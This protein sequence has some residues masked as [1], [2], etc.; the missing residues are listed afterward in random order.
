MICD[1]NDIHALNLIKPD[2]ECVSLNKLNIIEI[3]EFP[4][5]IKALRF[6]DCI[7]N[8]C[9]KLRLPSNL[10]NLRII[11]RIPRLDGLILPN[12]LRDLY[13]SST[14]LSDVSLLHF[15]PTLE[16][17]NLSYNCIDDVSMLNLPNS[18]KHLD[19]GNNRIKYVKQLK[20]P[21]L[22]EILYLES[23]II[24]DFPTLPSNLT[25]LYLSHNKIQDVSLLKLPKTLNLHLVESLKLLT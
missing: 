13:I 20:L 17:L 1:F 21:E 7:I 4:K 11:D 2:M 15:P 19:L 25:E 24:C 5:Y 12:L 23:N 3:V 10:L 9:G 14:T 18:L 16:H 8:D 22:L 6:R